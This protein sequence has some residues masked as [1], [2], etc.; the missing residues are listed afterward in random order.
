M[1]KVFL[2]RSAGGRPVAVKVIR[3]DLAA[4]SEFRARFRREVAAAQKVNGLYT[5]LVVDADVDGPMPWLATAYVAGPSLADAVSSHGP[6]PVASV[7]VLAAGLAEGLGAIHAVGLVHRDL[8]PSNVLLADDGPRVIDFGI[9]RTAEASVLTHSGLVVGSPG[10][11]SPEQAEGREVGRPSDVFSL[12]AVIA[13]AATGHGPFGSGPTAALVYRVVH[14]SPSLHDV[15]HEIR[16]V[17]ERCLAKD[18]SLRPTTAELLAELGDVDL[19]ADWLPATIV[20]REPRSMAPERMTGVSAPSPSAAEAPEADFPAAHG[21]SPNAGVASGQESAGWTALNDAPLDAGRGI[22]ARP[23]PELA[24]VYGEHP[25]T[26]PAAAQQRP[27]AE[28]HIPTATAIRTDAP[29]PPVPGPASAPSRSRGSAERAVRRAGK[30]GRIFVATG[31]V[32]A[33]IAIVLTFV[34]IKVNSKA[35]PST[36][37]PSNSQPKAAPATI[38]DKVTMVPVSTLNAVGKGGG[39]VTGLPQ[40]INGPPLK[41]NGKPE[42]LYMGAEYCPY[43]G[44]ERWAL[45]VAL[46]RFGTFSGLATVRS[47]ASNGAGQEEPYPNMSTWTFAH[48]TYN[49][50]Y[51]AFTG[52]ELQTNIPDAATGG[53]TNLQTPTSAEQALLNRY[54]VPPYVPAGSEG[55]IPFVDFGNKYITTGTSYNPQVLVGLSWSQIATDLS[56]PSSPVAAAID[57]TANYITAAICSMTDNQPARAC[58]A[59]VRSLENQLK[60]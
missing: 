23:E 42:M 28:E 58:T 7:Q 12:G 30:R 1:G 25:A 38:A 5:A 31:S 19:E 43:C 52:V 8:K 18:A 34:L 59:V 60:S 50:K 17:A 22:D 13:F 45:I 55:A 21:A 36:G 37:S 10:F 6:L 56:N 4:D 39:A 27:S 41:A 3:A 15:P 48:V 2:G 49:S 57:G 14:G 11:M 51:L 54:D 35:T 33:V 32:F 44:A 20:E 16:S 47:A 9:S 53:Y 40:A 46:S 26:A 29:A 24:A